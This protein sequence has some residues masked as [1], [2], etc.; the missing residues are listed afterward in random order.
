MGSMQLDS[1]AE[2]ACQEQEDQTI[3]G[4]TMLSTANDWRRME[5]RYHIEHKFHNLG[6]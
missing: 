3:N 6:K 5:K 1:N 2:G 4:H